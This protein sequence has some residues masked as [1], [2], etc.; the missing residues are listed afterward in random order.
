MIHTFPDKRKI[1]HLPCILFCPWDIYSPCIWM[2]T[3]INTCFP[4]VRLLLQDIKT[5]YE[6]CL[7]NHEAS[8][9]GRHFQLYF[10][11][12]ESGPES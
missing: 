3:L 11:G 10:K 9:Q 6:H 1:L 2:P 5:H 4:Y 12:I 8:L 7:V